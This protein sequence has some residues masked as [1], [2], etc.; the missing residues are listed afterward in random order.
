MY[1]KEAKM[2]IYC[3]GVERYKELWSLF[4]EFFYI[5]MRVRAISYKITAARAASFDVQCAI[6]GS[7]LHFSVQTCLNLLLCLPFK[8]SKKSVSKVYVQ[9]TAIKRVCQRINLVARIM[10]LAV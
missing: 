1:H 2:T 7:V 3:Y 6:I 10:S 9:I 4:V 8:N 5:Q